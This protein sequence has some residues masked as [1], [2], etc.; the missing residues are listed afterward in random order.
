MT[1]FSQLWNRLLENSSSDRLQLRPG[2]R[3]D[4][5]EYMENGF[6]FRFPATM[7]AFFALQQ[8]QAETA[9]QPLLGDWWS[10]SFEESLEC[11]TRMGNLASGQAMPRDQLECQGPLQPALGLRGW[12]PM[13][14][15][16][17]S[18]LLCFDLEPADGGVEGQL[19][20]VDLGGSTRKVVAASLEDFLAELMDQQP[21][22]SGP[23]LPSALP[24]WE[25]LVEWLEHN[26]PRVHRGLSPGTPEAR[27]RLFFRQLGLEPP[28]AVREFF[29]WQGGQD[30]S[31]PCGLLEGW[32]LLS[33]DE[34]AGHYET[35]L[36]TARL[37][38]VR[39]DW[40]ECEG[41]VKPLY[42]SP[43]WLPVAHDHSGN[44]ICIDLDPT[45]EGAVGQVIEVD[46]DCSHRR[47][48]APGLAA[49]LEQLHQRLVSGEL[50]LE[51]AELE[52]E[53]YL[54]E[55]VLACSLDQPLGNLRL[56]EENVVITRVEPDDADCPERAVSI[57]I[58][59]LEAH[60]HLLEPALDGLRLLDADGV[61]ISYSCGLRHLGSARRY[62]IESQFELTGRVDL[63]LTLMRKLRPWLK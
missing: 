12:V 46:F 53:T 25:R 31:S 7:R 60:P 10:L 15:H 52:P 19:V 48:L 11:W 42:A 55:N 36:D 29:G 37:G 2:A 61:E 22:P 24:A 62:V 32:S 18:R 16:G 14:R 30:D 57:L 44:L 56:A 4:E 58:D 3:P 23:D 35:M 41:P 59:G 40:L 49:Y 27:L 6:G 13:A 26:S 38:E 1:G 21:L 45:P 33:L 8:G 50:E 28:P 43:L 51:D 9:S 17:I 34:I 5:I 20:E 54:F 39:L 63:K 47:V